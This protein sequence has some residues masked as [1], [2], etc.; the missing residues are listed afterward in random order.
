M[1]QKFT[2]YI[3]EFSKDKLLA[4]KKL[5]EEIFG[6]KEIEDIVFLDKRTNRLIKTNE[7]VCKLGSS[8]ILSVIICKYFTT[9]ESNI[10]A[11]EKGIPGLT[12]VL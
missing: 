1:L 5:L 6:E 7:D 3:A 9:A 8:S 4:N 12:S 10:L 2:G 11:D